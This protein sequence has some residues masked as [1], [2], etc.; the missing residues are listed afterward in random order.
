MKKIILI[1]IS[2]LTLFSCS[3][4]LGNYDYIEINQIDVKGIDPVINCDQM[5]ILKIDVDIDGTLY[6]D[7]DLFEYAWEINK[8]IVSN[9]KNLE[10]NAN[11]PLGENDA[12]YIVTDKRI[13]TKSFNVFKINISSA[14]AGDGILV[15]SKYKGRG[16]LS[17]KRLDKEGT[18]FSPNYYL[19]LNGSILG[20]NPKKIHRNYGPEL[21]NSNSGINIEIDGKLK[22]LS[23]IT[24]LEIGLNKYI[25]QYYFTNRGSVYPPIIEAFDVST[26]WQLYLSNSPFGMVGH[27]K[28]LFVIANGQL[29]SDNLVQIP[30]MNISLNST[31]IQKKSPLGG[32]LAPSMFLS[33]LSLSGAQDV[34]PSDYLY[35]YDKTH[36]K[37]LYTG[38]SGDNILEIPSLNAYQGYDMLYATHT[39]LKNYCVAVINNG[40]NYK[41]LYLRFPSTNSEITSIGYSVV[42]EITAPSNIINNNT[43]FYPMKNE[44]YL[45]FTTNDNIYNVNIRS[46]EDGNNLSDLKEIA[47]LQKYGYNNDAKIAC[48]T[49]S[50]TENE[51]ILGVSRY[52]DDTNGDSD[53]LKGDVL[54]IDRKTMELIKKYDSVSGYPVDIIIKYQNFLRDG[55]QD[56]NNVSD[57]LYF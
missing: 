3:E 56:G 52:G 48:L 18:H 22:S 7:P 42:N 46:F 10:V 21:T 29:F 54:V 37:F 4:D 38:L 33:S 34:T 43:S 25:D 5:D 35:L 55:K 6:S 47:S 45:Y 13:G 24:L 39:S 28:H 30:A 40:D 53:E 15:L 23:E 36:G 32:S 2:L 51:I 12:R 49:F 16:E 44:P 17:Y 50:R 14:T 20:N 8:R 1:L 11:F 41:L 31:K 57:K 19:E 26:A 9:K 27:S